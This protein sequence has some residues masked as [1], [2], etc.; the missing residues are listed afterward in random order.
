MIAELVGETRER[1]QGG[2]SQHPDALEKGLNTKFEI[3][4]PRKGSKSDEKQEAGDRR[5]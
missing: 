4:S 1:L 5:E 3:N 2:P